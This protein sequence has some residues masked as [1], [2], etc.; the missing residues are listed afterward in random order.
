MEANVISVQTNNDLNDHPN[1]SLEQEHH[2]S[3]N[4]LKGV[5]CTVTLQFPGI[6]SG[7]QIQIL[8][9]SAIQTSSCNHETNF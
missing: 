7:M 6:I 3:F 5:S 2:L 9:N 1:H 8:P 4:T